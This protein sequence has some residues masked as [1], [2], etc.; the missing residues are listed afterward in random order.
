MILLLLF[1][2]LMS[3]L[4]NEMVLTGWYV[5]WLY[6]GSIFCWLQIKGSDT[7]NSLPTQLVTLYTMGTILYFIHILQHRPLGIVSVLL[8][9]MIRQVKNSAG[10]TN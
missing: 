8:I 2:I 7:A 6:S 3:V 4:N 5:F 9:N 10:R 1:F